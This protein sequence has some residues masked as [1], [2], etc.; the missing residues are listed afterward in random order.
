MLLPPLAYQY[1]GFPQGP[2]PGHYGTYPGS[3]ANQ[4]GGYP[5]QKPPG[6]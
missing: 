5:N 4:Q 2:P 3:Y 6:W 1:Q